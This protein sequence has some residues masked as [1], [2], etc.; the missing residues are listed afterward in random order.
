MAQQPLHVS[1]VGSIGHEV[2]GARMPP[3]VGRDVLLNAGVSAILLHHDFDGLAF[4][5][6]MRLF[7]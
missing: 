2:G 7:R 5:R 3:H 6:A 1:D 4:E